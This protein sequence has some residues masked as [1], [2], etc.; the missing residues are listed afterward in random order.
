MIDD[1]LW[2]AIAAG[3]P[4]YLDRQRWYADKLR[5]ISAVTLVDV[6][7]IESRNSVILLALIEIEYQIGDL[8]RY[9]IPMAVHADPTPERA[10]IAIAGSDG[11]SRWVQDAVSDLD[12]RNFLVE[13]GTRLDVSA[14]HGVFAFEPWTLDGLPFRI[15][16]AIQSAATAFEQ[17]NSSIAYGEQVMAKLYR[18]LEVGQNIEVDMNRY[19]ASEAGFLST[20][21]LIAAATYRGMAGEFPL[22]LVQQHVGDHRDAWTALTD[23]LRHKVNGSLEFVEGLGRVTGEMHVALASAPSTSPL[24]PELITRDDIDSWRH[25][26]LRSAQETDWITGE[27]LQILPALSQQA[28]REYL[29]RPRDWLERSSWFDLLDGFYKTRVHG[30]YHLGQVLVT[31][32]GRLL[33]VDFEGEPHRPAHEREAKYSPL[34]DVAGMLRSLNYATGVIASTHDVQAVA[35][36]RSWLDDWE[37]DARGRFLA[38][39]RKAIST[40]PIPIAPAEDDIF[41]RVIAALETDKAFYEVRYEFSSRPDWAWLPLDSLK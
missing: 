18:R 24:A 29:A 34:R 37:R 32:D 4:A 25:A 19:L 35:A 17:S 2:Q 21:K 39:Y 38:A 31:K 20:P 10:T 3:L 1:A 27:R 40:S 6:A 22:L 30:D 9:F 7:T 23:L 14:N 15:D 11:Q 33:V 16:P 12:F 26:F 41:E 28:A 36:S 8:R 13:T 5:P